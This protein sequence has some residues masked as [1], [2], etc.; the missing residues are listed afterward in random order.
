MILRI[1]A[2]FMCLSEAVH[3]RQNVKFI[4]ASIKEPAL[5]TLAAQASVI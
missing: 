4:W 3:L 1:S 2:G 5:E